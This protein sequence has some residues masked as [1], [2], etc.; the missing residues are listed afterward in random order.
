MPELFNPA[1][2][3]LL[4]QLVAIGFFQVVSMIALALMLRLFIAPQT[5]A[6]PIQVGGASS[7]VS[8]WWI[9][10]AIL[11]ANAVL[12][13]AKWREHVTAEKL[14]QD[15]IVDC[16][17]AA[18]RHLS[19]MSV[20]AQSQFRGGSLQLRFVNDLSALRQWVALGL[21]RL[22]IAGIV[23]IVATISLALLNPILG[24]VV[25]GVMLIAIGGALLIGR[26][27][28]ASI[29]EARKRRGLIA[30]NTAEK[31]NNMAVVQAFAHVDPERRKVRAQANALRRAMIARASVTGTFRGFMAFVVSAGLVS[32]VAIGTAQSALADMLLA[33][34]LFSLI[35]PSLFQLGRVYEYHR[36]AKIAH[37]KLSALF[38]RGPLILPA[39]APKAMP[40]SFRRLRVQRA[41]LEGI[42][43][44]VTF[45][46][47][48]GERVIVKGRNGAGKSTLI[49]MIMRLIEPDSGTI[50]LNGKPIEDFRTGQ[51]RRTISIVSPHLPLLKGT[52]R[53][54]IAYGSAKADEAQI[55]EAARACGLAPV[56]PGSRLALDREVSEG[57][58]N[59]SAGEKMR[60]I[61]ARALVGSPQ[62]L[63]LDEPESH[64]DKETLALLREVLRDFPGA[65]LLATHS[66]FASELADNHWRLA[67]KTLKTK[68][69]GLQP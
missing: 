62:L 51:L 14:G 30:A 54:N 24:A 64:L 34:T 56:K 53:Y 4:A 46:I 29:R 6:G 37:E 61:I 38:T 26:A 12:A 8:L 21:A 9:F 41:S 28:D 42:L 66:D 69:E 55:V 5:E 40:Q 2:A 45:Q 60:M 25:G 65:W 17:I 58:A 19:A 3:R 16:R 47:R 57:G 27:F 31:I 32:I 10:A 15:Y 59:L 23:L 48:A 63:L 7:E 1:R 43:R 11:A 49:R 36:S 50:T 35:S 20:H 39:P 67:N 33:L 18:F 22:V 68:T 44:N 13:I 52:V